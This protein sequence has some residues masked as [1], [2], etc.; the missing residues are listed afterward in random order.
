M[1]STKTSITPIVVVAYNRPDCLLRIL[2]S[3]AQ[4][5][6]TGFQNIPLI[7]S[8][9]YHSDNGKVLTVAENF[10]WKYGEKKIKSHSSN[11]GLRRH[12]IECGNFA[13][14][15]GSVIV[16][17]DDLFVAPSFYRYASEALNFSQE[18]NYIG[19]ISL[20]NHQLNAQTHKNFSPLE[21]GF[22]NWYFQFAASWG[23]G[24]T[25][26]QW[27]GF[28]LWYENNQILEAKPT[29]PINVTYWSEKSWLK[30]YVAYLIETDKYF[31]YPKVAL[32]SNFSEVGTHNFS[33]STAFQVTL[34]YKIQ[35]KFKFSSL[36]QS[37]SVYD[38]FY[39]NKKLTQHIDLNNKNCC[40]DLYAFKPIPSNV[41]YLLTTK[42]LSFT[43]IKSFGKS[44]KPVDLNIIF[45]V[46]GKDI[47]LYDLSKPHKNKFFNNRYNELT[48]NYKI[49]TFKDAGY[50][51]FKIGL[52]RLGNLKRKLFS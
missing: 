10:V 23:Q 13:L 40:V 39:E 20:Y 41:R 12:I 6:Y 33:G 38:A 30:F 44:L 1:S 49:I 43:I 46:P 28:M 45:N 50:L 14:E 3:L 27:E 31:L 17:E 19:G 51:F 11:L 2:N 4:A 26:P 47:F 37:S 18:K 22:D 25:K 5:D 36:D 42:K 9:D 32:S 8:I 34:R 48:Y 24:W 21:D 35:S 52:I 16:F 7:I 15:Y 29:I